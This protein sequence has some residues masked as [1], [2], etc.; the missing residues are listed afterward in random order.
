MVVVV[1][2]VAVVVALLLP[3]VV[4]LLLVVVV[5][6]LLVLLL[7]LLLLVLDLVVVS[8][9]TAFKCGLLCVNLH[10]RDALCLGRRLQSSRRKKHAQL[11]YR[12]LQE[13]LRSQDYIDSVP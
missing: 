2:V 12:V 1:L 11:F 6:L 4:L 9:G 13:R 7:L 3:V 8:W 10:D 5:V